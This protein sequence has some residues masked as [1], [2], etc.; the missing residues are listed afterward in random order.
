MIWHGKVHLMIYIIED[1][2]EQT[3][4]GDIPVELQGSEEWRPLPSKLE[5]KR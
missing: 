1:K 3:H 5:P 2:V 4:P